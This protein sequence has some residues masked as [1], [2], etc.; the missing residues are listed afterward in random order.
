MLLDA[1]IITLDELKEIIEREPDTFSS[2]GNQM[3]LYDRGIITEQ[4][5]TTFELKYDCDEVYRLLD[6]SRDFRDD[7]VAEILCGDIGELSDGW[8]YY[9]DNPSDLVNLTRCIASIPEQIL[10][11]C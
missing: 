1:G 10:R 4:P 6:I 3:K 11:N 8:S 9:Y 7:L 5:S 2:F